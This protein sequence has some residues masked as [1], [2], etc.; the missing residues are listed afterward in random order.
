MDKIQ[1]PNEP[2]FWEYRYRSGLANWDLG[3]PSPVFVE[4]L[5]NN[6]LYGAG[7]IAILGSGNGY[8]AILFAKHDFLVTAIDF[9]PSALASTRKQAKKFHLT[10]ETIQANLFELPGKLLNKFDYILEYVTYCAI[11]P[12]RRKEYIDNIYRLLRPGGVL[13]GLFFPIDKREGGPPFSVDIEKLKSNFKKNFILLHSE[14]PQ[15][16]VAPRLEKE[17]LMLWKKKDV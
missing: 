17:I 14:I 10:V 3:T 16:S 4:L 9:A 5:K 1:N 6:L 11:D 7:K 2:D 12:K 13:I 15:S 8:D